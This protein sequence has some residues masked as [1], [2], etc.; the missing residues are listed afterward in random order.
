MSR[1]ANND[2]MQKW[3]IIIRNQQESKLSAEK[4]CLQN[5]I[6]IHTFKYWKTRLGLVLKRSSFIEIE[7]SK[8]TEFLILECNNVRIHVDSSFNGSL[9][10]RCLI[11][12][13]AISC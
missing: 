5:N 12:I 1:P 8:P 6:S 11:A 4:W 10:Q 2:K 9:L 3:E 7:T 13:K